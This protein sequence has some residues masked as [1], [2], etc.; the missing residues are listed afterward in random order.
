VLKLGLIS[1]GVVEGVKVVIIFAL[2]V[3]IA[4]INPLIYCKEDNI[5]YRQVSYTGKLATLKT[6]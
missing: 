1:R 4:L 3:A 6:H 2:A 5:P